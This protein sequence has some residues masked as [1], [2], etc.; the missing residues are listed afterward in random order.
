MQGG[1]GFGFPRVLVLHP[2]VWS[3]PL[4]PLPPWHHRVGWGHPGISSVHSPPGMFALSPAPPSLQIRPSPSLAL[5]LFLF[6]P[7]ITRFKI[8]LAQS[9]FI[10]EDIKD[11]LDILFRQKCFFLLP[12]TILGIQLVCWIICDE[13]TNT[14]N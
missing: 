9:S 7:D 10:Y 13:P 1:F 12:P 3:R 6:F 5:L 4:P 2:V 11:A 8:L 14:T